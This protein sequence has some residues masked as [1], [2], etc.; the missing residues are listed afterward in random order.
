M[1]VAAFMASGKSFD[2]LTKIESTSL[3]GE[4]A[5]LGNIIEELASLGELHSNIG[6]LKL[7]SRWLHH[8]SLSREAKNLD[9]IR[10]L[11][12]LENFSF[13]RRMF[14]TPLSPKNL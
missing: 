12:G 3:R 13:F 8:F 1:A 11:A 2:Q 10:M 9:Y 6:P 7:G 5:S 14:T 4:R